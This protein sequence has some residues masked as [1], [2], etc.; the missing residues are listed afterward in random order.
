MMV[1]TVEGATTTAVG[2]TTADG[3]TM[4][5][6]ATPVDGAATADG[7]ITASMVDISG[8]LT[9]IRTGITPPTTRT[10]IL[11]TMAMSTRPLPIRL[12]RFPSLANRSN[13]IGTTVR[14]QT[15]IIHT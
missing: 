11:M 2:A 13:P 5:V 3:A 6:E 7:A 9:T 8:S 14:I 15:P 10:R 1:D 12:L 4:V